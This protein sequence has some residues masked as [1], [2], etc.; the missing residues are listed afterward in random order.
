[1]PSLITHTVVGVSAALPLLQSLEVR[2]QI[3][4]AML[5]L[6]AVVFSCLPDFDGA[7]LGIIPY[8]S[9]FGHRGFFH[10]PAFLL[11]FTALCAYVYVR[12]VR[13]GSIRAATRVLLLW[14]GVAISHSLLDALT[15]GGRG[16][17]L[18]FPFSN[19]RYFFPWRPIRVSPIGI[20]VFWYS[21]SG[22][23]R[24]ELP[25]CV[26]ALGLGGVTYALLRREP[27]S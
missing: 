9:F 4:A 27:G 12:K 18:L 1:M 21:A 23:L 15:D 6:S 25:F 22:V 7:F 8:G 2:K 11:V 20:D 10:S 19:S 17:M 13:E 14:A 24:S 16:V 5:I 3:S 26:V